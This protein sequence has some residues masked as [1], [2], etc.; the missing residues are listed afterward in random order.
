MFPLIDRNLPHVEDAIL[1]YLGPRELGQSALVCKDWYHKTKTLLCRW[2]VVTQRSKGMV[3][4]IEA[5]RSGYDHLVCYLLKDKNTF[6][7]ERGTSQIYH[8]Q[9]IALMVAASYGHD[10]IQLNCS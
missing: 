2:Y 6:V 10:K 5:V 3:P 1:S 9:S 8:C 4:L 7:N